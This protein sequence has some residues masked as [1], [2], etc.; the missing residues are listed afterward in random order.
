MNELKLNHIGIVVKDIKKSLEDY[1]KNYGFSQVSDI[2]DVDNQDVR[3]VMLNSG[4]DVNIELIEPIDE[5]SPAYNALKRGGGLNHLCYETKFFD[6]MLIKFR[7]KIVRSPREA[8][9]DLFGGRRT[10]F[11]FR[12]HSLIEFLEK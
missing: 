10:F 3:V 7:G 1:L 11:I 12:K 2:I 4:S 6:D 9:K 5:T 8:P